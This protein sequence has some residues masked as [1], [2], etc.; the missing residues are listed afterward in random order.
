MIWIQRV[1]VILLVIGMITPMVVLA[2]IDPANEATYTL[3]NFLIGCLAGLVGV[4][5][6]PEGGSQ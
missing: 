3:L 6:W 2:T 1:G 5:L 4:L